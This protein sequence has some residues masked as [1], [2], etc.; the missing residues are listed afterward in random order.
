M[1]NILT[2]SR[3][4]CFQSCPRQHYWRYEIGLQSD[5]E[6]LALFI[7]SAW[8]RAM[9]ARTQG[10]DFAESM[11]A[12]WPDGMQMD[13]LT[14][15][16][17]KGLLQ[18]YFQVYGMC[19]RDATRIAEKQFKFPLKGVKGF[20]VEGKIDFIS[21]NKL[22][23]Y[24]TTGESIAPDSIYW[25][26][27]RFNTQ[28]L[29]YVL[30]ARA[31]GYR[32]EEIN[33]DVVRKPSIAPKMIEDLDEQGLKIVL[34]STGKRV[35]T[36][37]KAC[38]GG[39]DIPVLSANKKNGWTV[40]KHLETPAEFGERLYH[41]CLAR[42]DFYFARREIPVLESDLFDFEAQRL[43]IAK[44]ILNH[45]KLESKNVRPEFAW[46]RHVSVDTCTFCQFKSFCLQNL[47][48]NPKEPPQGFAIKAFN[49]ELAEG[50]E[51]QI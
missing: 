28:I 10:K 5:S 46:P 41:D 18:A 25:L 37:R 44:T 1:N 17:I 27:L 13:E 26:R 11:Q 49:P 34:D 36:K 45:R 14:A 19:E 16:K 40:K 32:I 8:H 15:H 30:A 29:Q 31:L 50:T 22:D 42:P 48:I 7:G 47:N 12:A 24:K 35:F 3:S 20:T 2:A 9:E 51:T 6:S 21:G 43:S 4:N 39:G 33:Y 23:E 38:D